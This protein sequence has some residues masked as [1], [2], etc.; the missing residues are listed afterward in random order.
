MKTMVT[1][2][3]IFLPCLSN[4]PHRS[5]QN[6]HMSNCIDDMNC[7]HEDTFIEIGPVLASGPVEFNFHG[8][9]RRYDLR[10]GTSNAKRI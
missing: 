1:D 5:V 9:P 3:N 2:Y 4:V 8:M 7:R 10:F 6:D